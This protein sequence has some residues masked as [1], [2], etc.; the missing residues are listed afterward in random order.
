MAYT[1]TINLALDKAVVGTNQ[2]FETAKVNSNWDKIDGAFEA[3]ELAPRVQDVADEGIIIS[4]G[5]A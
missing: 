1:Q 4:G 3:E 2:A 5:T